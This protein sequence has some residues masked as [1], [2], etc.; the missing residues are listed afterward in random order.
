MLDVRQKKIEAMKSTSLHLAAIAATALGLLALTG[1]KSLSPTKYSISGAVG[2][3]GEH[4]SYKPI[5]VDEAIQKLGGLNVDADPTRVYLDRGYS[6]SVTDLKSIGSR[7]LESGM[8]VTIPTIGENLEPRR[9]L[10]KA[11]Q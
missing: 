2:N 4:V 6:G 9:I 3:P 7:R 5:T 11:E 1:C 10:H 8:E